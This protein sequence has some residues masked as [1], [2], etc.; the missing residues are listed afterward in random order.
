MN[1]FAK[2]AVAAAAVVAVALVGIS[3]LPRPGGV[4]APSQNA[5]PVPSPSPTPILLPSAGALGP[6]TYYMAAGP[7]T[8]ARLTFTVPAGWATEE[9][10]V[11]KGPAPGASL[12][13]GDVSDEELLM[14]TWKVTHVYDDICQDRTLTTAGTTAAQLASALRAQKGRAISAPT[15][16]TLGGFPATRME[17][18]I[19]ADLDVSTCDGGIIRFW[20]DP[21]PAESGGLCCSAPG[22]TDVV[23]VVDVAG[24][25]FAVVARH[26]ANSS[27]GDIAE[28]DNIVASIR[29]EPST[30]SPAPSSSP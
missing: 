25:P 12:S 15:S 3:V 23:Y 30:P 4:A 13:P 5:T 14:V 28:L 1:S 27:A 10:F 2:L 18:T 8:P 11:F 29:L 21:G 24:E 6:G 20:P 19:P 26:Q 16:V 9:G 17:L 7:I 22:S